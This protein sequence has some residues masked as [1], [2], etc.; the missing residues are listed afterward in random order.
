MAESDFFGNQGSLESTTTNVPPSVTVFPDVV[1]QPIATEHEVVAAGETLRQQQPFDYVHFVSFLGLRAISIFPIEDVELKEPSHGPP[2]GR[3]VSMSVVYGKVRRGKG[4]HM[5]VAVKRA[6]NLV[7]LGRQH[8]AAQGSTHETWLLDLFFEL[9]IMAHS[10]IQS[11]NNIVRLLG[12]AFDHWD[13]DAT[14]PPTPWVIVEP[15]H[16]VFINL[17]R[18]FE[19]K[20]RPAMAHIHTACSLIADVADGLATLHVHS[21]WFSHHSSCCAG[22]IYPVL[23]G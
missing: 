21:G 1:G 18:Y 4:T 17:R 13:S 6:A 16:E 15:A 9:Q 19:N 23:C 11:S 3:G 22:A 14:Q 12:I 5:P 8:V 10:S 7:N 20:K 2:A